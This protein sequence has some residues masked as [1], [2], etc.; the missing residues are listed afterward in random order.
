MWPFALVYGFRY[1]WDKNYRRK[2][3]KRFDNRLNR[4]RYGTNWGAKR[5]IFIFKL[6]KRDGVGCN[7]CRRVNTKMTIDHI[8]PLFAG[9]ENI[10]A[11]VQLLCNVCHTEKSKSE[12]KRYAP[13]NAH[14][15]EALKQQAKKIKAFRRKEKGVGAVQDAHP[16]KVRSNLL[17]VRQDGPSRLKLAHGALHTKRKLRSVP[18]VRPTQPTAPVLPLQYKLGGQRYGVF[19]HDAGEGG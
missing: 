12:L 10:L 2:C 3:K 19:P 17:H 8:V 6:Q 9:G 5:R 13:N 7:K 15:K 18:T 16:G 4:E 1:Y 11:N 14:K